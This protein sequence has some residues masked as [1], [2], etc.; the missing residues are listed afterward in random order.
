MT[1]TERESRRAVAARIMYLADV[2]PDVAVDIRAAAALILKP[3]DDEQA[4]IY[5]AELFKRG[6][7]SALTPNQ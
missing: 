7:R 6:E 1:D 3:I 2:W 4:G 5:E